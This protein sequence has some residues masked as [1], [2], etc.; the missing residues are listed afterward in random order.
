[1]Q[2]ANNTI[3]TFHSIRNDYGYVPGSGTNT[4]ESAV[5]SEG[6]PSFGCPAVTIV[7]VT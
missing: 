5:I 7:A 4:T 3:F 1:M 2:F 6:V